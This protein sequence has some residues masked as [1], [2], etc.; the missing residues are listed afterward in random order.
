MDH[1]ISVANMSDV[2]FEFFSHLTIIKLNLSY[3]ALYSGP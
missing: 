1:R 2:D 3:A